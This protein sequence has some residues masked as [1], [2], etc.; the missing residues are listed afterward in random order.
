MVLGEEVP[1]DNVAN[2]S[3]NIVRVE[4][5]TTEASNDGVC[6]A[7]ECYGLVRIG[8]GSGCRGG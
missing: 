7:S 4:P 3:D 5:E 1:L 8:S 6:C 2:L